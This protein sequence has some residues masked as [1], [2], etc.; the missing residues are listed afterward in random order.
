MLRSVATATSFQPRLETFGS[1]VKWIRVFELDDISC[2]K[3]AAQLGPGFNHNTIRTWEN[4]SY[5]P[6]RAHEVARRYAEIAR[7]AGATHITADWIMYGGDVKIVLGPS[8]SHIA[9]THVESHA[10]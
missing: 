3:L 5:I 6:R 9:F 8:G 2:V 10:A 1:R 7:A 4:G